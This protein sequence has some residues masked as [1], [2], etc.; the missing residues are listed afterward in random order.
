M[1]LRHCIDKSNRSGREVADAE[2]PQVRV[3]RV[4]RI[5]GAIHLFVQFVLGRR[6]ENLEALEILVLPLQCRTERN[7]SSKT[8]AIT[9][10][11]LRR[12]ARPYDGDVDRRTCLLIL[13][14]P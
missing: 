7:G 1:P 8:V 13:R 11:T 6:L 9:R 14:D 12:A 3:A 2:E 10:A 4:D 5:I